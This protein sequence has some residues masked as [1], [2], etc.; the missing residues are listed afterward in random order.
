MLNRRR[1]RHPRP[2]TP[3]ADSHRRRDIPSSFLSPAAADHR[4]PRHH[5]SSPSCSSIARAGTVDQGL[6]S[7]PPPSAALLFTVVA[8][9]RRAPPSPPPTNTASDQRHPSSPPI[10]LT[11]VLLRPRPLPRPRPRRLQPPTHA[12]PRRQYSSPS[13]SCAAVAA[14]RDRRSPLS[15]SI[16]L[17]F[18]GI[19]VISPLNTAVLTELR[20]K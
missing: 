14:A 9:H 5:C 12:T 16:V 3:A 4:R 1:R 10:I 11:V 13:C 8:P 17:L 18:T 7:P 2:Q 6:R 15:Q 19:S 20:D